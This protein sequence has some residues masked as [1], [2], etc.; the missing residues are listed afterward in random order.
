VLLLPVATLLVGALKIRRLRRLGWWA[1]VFAA[2]CV[3]QLALAAG[4]T[5][6][7]LALH[8]LNGALLL[9]ASIVLVAKVERRRRRTSMLRASESVS[10]STAHGA[11]PAAPSKTY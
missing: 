2:L 1:G 9:C 4:P 5:P 7:L 11:G 3:A 6:P 10:S 8:P